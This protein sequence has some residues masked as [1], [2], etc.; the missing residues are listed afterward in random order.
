MNFRII[1]ILS[2]ATL[3]VIFITQNTAVVEVKF[4]FWSMQISRSLLIFILLAIGIVIGIVS[5]WS[6]RTHFISKDIKTT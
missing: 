5:G 2:L 3:V 1:S 4:L 6:L